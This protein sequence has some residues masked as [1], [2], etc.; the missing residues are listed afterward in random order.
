M[1]KVTGQLDMH[2]GASLLYAFVQSQILP[3]MFTIYLNPDRCTHTYATKPSDRQPMQSGEGKET[4]KKLSRE[5]PRSRQAPPYAILYMSLLHIPHITTH[6]KTGFQMQKSYRFQRLPCL[7]VSAS[8]CLS[9]F[10]LLSY[11]SAL[12]CFESGADS[13]IIFLTGA[14]HLFAFSDAAFDALVASLSM[15]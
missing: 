2:N 8:Y 10:L 11:S 3:R 7:L 9:F 1:A 5:L 15:V 14:I 4:A 13:H 6:S 12:C